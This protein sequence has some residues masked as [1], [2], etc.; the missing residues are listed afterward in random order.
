MMIRLTLIRIQVK[1]KKHVNF[2]ER[3]VPN[4]QILACQPWAGRLSPWAKRLLTRPKFKIIIA[5]ALK[6]RAFCFLN[7]NR[8]EA[9]TSHGLGR[10]P[11]SEWRK[12]RSKKQTTR[13]RELCIVLN[14]VSCLIF[15]SLYKDCVVYNIVSCI[16]LKPIASNW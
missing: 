9:S 13:I 1:S 12:M 10:H 16:K 4:F 5:G 14:I 6:L 11:K 2:K 15:V 8:S 7:T 3:S